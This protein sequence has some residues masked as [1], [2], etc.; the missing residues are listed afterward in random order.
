MYLVYNKNK[1]WFQSAKKSLLK[2]DEKWGQMDRLIMLC[3]ILK[4]CFAQSLSWI[5]FHNWL[6]CD[7]IYFKL[8]YPVD[9][10]RNKSG[11][12]L[13]NPSKQLKTCLE[14]SNLKET[15][16]FENLLNTQTYTS[17]NS[18]ADQLQRFHPPP[19][20]LY[21]I[22]LHTHTHIHTTCYYRA[23]GMDIGYTWR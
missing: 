2:F 6:H 17:L 23:I 9:Y 13:H 3:L 12:R 22:L 11:E 19:P 14:I 8:Q 18:F 1:Q 7:D 21:K 4:S 15:T 16:V 10:A 20:F 5:S